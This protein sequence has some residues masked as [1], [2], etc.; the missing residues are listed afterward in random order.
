M[1]MP[2]EFFIIMLLMRTIKK[3]HL[4]TMGTFNRFLVFDMFFMDEIKYA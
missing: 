1:G 3:I 2:N 4:L